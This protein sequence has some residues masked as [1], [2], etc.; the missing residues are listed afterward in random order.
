MKEYHIEKRQYFNEM[1]EPSE[2]YYHIYSI[3][4][5]LGLISYRKYITKTIFRIDN[6]YKDR[7]NFKSVEL[8]KEFI[9][10]ILCPE[11]PRAV[12]KREVVET[13][14]CNSK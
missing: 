13:V 6:C 1:G 5:F 4:K 3:K 10:N 14:K 8:A 12:L 11:I 7:I 9:S 2:P